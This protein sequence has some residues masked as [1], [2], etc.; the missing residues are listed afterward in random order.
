[1]FTER[2]GFMK[3]LALIAI[4][5]ILAFAGCAQTKGGEI[6]REEYV[7]QA[8]GDILVEVWVKAPAGSAACKLRG[9]TEQDVVCLEYDEGRI[10][11]PGRIEYDGTVDPNGPVE[12]GQWLDIAVYHLVNDEGREVDYYKRRF[13]RAK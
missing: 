12:A 11:L 10:A 4:F 2:K 13:A 3:A 5:G 9:D 7:P 8:N 1:V 6:T